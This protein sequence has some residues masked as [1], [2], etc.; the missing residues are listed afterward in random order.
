MDP[1]SRML[2]HPANAR[3]GHRVTFWWIGPHPVQTL[4]IWI[5]RP[6]TRPHLA[7]T[8]LSTPQPRVPWSRRHLSIP[9]STT[10][11]PPNPILNSGKIL[12]VMGTVGGYGTLCLPANSAWLVMGVTC[13]TGTWALAP[14]LSSLSARILAKELHA[15]RPSYKLLQTITVANS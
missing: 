12:S 15:R 11:L 8:C 13:G 14:V 9:P 10:F 4:M 1:L 6:F 7:T 2:L 5:M 3:A